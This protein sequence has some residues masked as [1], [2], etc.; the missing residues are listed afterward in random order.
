MKEVTVKKRDLTEKL[1]ANRAAH[2][3]IFDE[4]VAG[5]QA[6]AEKLLEQHL[7]EVRAGKM[8]VVNVFLDVPED[9]TRDYD[10]VLGMLE[11]SVADEVTLSQQDFAMYVQDDWSWKRQFLTSNSTYSGT[12]ARALEG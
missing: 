6:M 9:H 7:A 2:R 12:A 4:A 3:A 8:K 1:T 11:M 10:R 5:Y